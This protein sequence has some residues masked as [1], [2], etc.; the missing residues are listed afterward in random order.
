MSS[1]LAKLLSL[2]YAISKNADRDSQQADKD[3]DSESAKKKTA[4]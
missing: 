4:D 1:P 2:I 3:Q